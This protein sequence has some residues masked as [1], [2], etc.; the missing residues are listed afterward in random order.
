MYHPSPPAYSPQQI[1][2][3]D[4]ME[5]LVTEREAADF[6]GYSTR[7]LQN[8]RLRGGGPRYVRVSGRSVR[9]RRRDLIEWADR[10]LLSNTSEAVSR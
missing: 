2:D 7:A 5:R 9:Y 3:R 6:L 10:R 1:Y 4:Y 8:W